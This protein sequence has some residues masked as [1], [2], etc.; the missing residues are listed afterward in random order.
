[1]GTC[2]SAGWLGVTR[3]SDPSVPCGHI[4][5]TVQEGTPN[6]QYLVKSKKVYTSRSRLPY[7]G[8]PIFSTQSKPYQVMNKAK[9]GY[10]KSK[11]IIGGTPPTVD[12]ITKGIPFFGSVPGVKTEEY[13]I[14][15]ALIV[16]EFRSALFFILYVDSGQDG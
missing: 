5:A 16:T 3:A 1:M 14:T 9:K 10:K 7:G 12:L 8:T 4:K 13:P 6:F 15:V 2:F 11:K